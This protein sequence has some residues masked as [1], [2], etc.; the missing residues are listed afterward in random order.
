MNYTILYIFGGILVL[1]PPHVIGIAFLILLHTYRR[2]SRQE[3]DDE[4]TND[5]EQLDAEQ[6]G[7]GAPIKN[8]RPDEKEYL[9]FESE[10]NNKEYERVQK[11]L[12]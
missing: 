12:R 4:Q 5:C 8:T 9:D 6:P 7:Y 2:L 11:K 1:V 10:F 3:N